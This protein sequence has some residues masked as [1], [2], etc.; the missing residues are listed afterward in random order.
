[1]APELL[2]SNYHAEKSADVYSFGVLMNE[3]VTEEEPFADQLTMML[4]RG[5]FAAANMAVQGKRPTMS[6]RQGR[7]LENLIKSCWHEDPKKRPTFA[8]LRNTVRSNSVVIPNW[9]QAK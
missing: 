8:E 3:I 7:A 1:M 5:P 2:D 4:G 6:T 9:S